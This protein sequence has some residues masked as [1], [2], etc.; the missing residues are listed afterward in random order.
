MKILLKILGISLLATIIYIIGSAVIPFSESF[1]EI[2]NQG[3]DP[4][5]LFYLLLVHIWITAT[6]FYIATKSEW[7]KN[8]IFYSEMFV[9]IGVYSFMTQTETLFF[10]DTFT[11]LSKTDGWL[12][13]LANA[14]ALIVIIPLTLILVKKSNS[15]SKPKTDIKLIEI[16]GKVLLLA[17]VYVLI[18]FLFGYF[19]AWQFADLREFYSGTAEKA[20]FIQI[21]TENFQNSNIIPFQFLRG[22]LFSV[23][24]L[25]VV[26]MLRN[27]RKEFLISLILIYTTTAIVL[28]IPNALFPETVR[29]AHFIEMLSSMS[30]FALITWVVWQKTGNTDATAVFSD[31]S[32]H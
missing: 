12:I 28:I 32:G 1:K 21:M 23:F 10:S 13:M 4:T 2:I 18:Y 20:S 24:I 5:D 6:V 29:W 16:L 26:F 31:N 27:K 19:V 8:R 7:N 17:G 3:A 14:I 30:L 25:P 9:F 22:I 15:E 11:A